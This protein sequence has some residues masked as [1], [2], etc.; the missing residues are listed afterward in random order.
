[1]NNK[2]E[3]KL[4]LGNIIQHFK[5]VCKHRHAVMKYAWKC[6]IPLQGLVH[7][8]SKFSPS[9]FFCNARYYTL[10]KSPIDVQRELFGYSPAWFH[11]KGRNKHHYEYWTDKYDSGCYVT[12]MPFK[13]TVEMLC[14]CI[15]ANEVYLGK[16]AS[17]KS[18]H[19]WWKTKRINIAMHPV[20]K[21]FL[22]YVF[23][24]LESMENRN[25]NGRHIKDTE[26]L[27]KEVLFNIY[28]HQEKKYNDIPYQVKLSDIRK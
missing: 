18:L 2:K 9:E 6:G 4:T 20:N 13:Y 12:K 5:T 23:L 22:D 10:G 24:R 7:D 3:Y 8:L 11:H 16:E 1:M 17:Y 25:I 15:A 19:Q 21:H 14:D 27:N 26:I 28:A